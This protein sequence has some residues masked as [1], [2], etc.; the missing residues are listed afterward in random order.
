[1]E[2]ENKNTHWLR[3]DYRV[4]SLFQIITGLDISIKILVKRMKAGGWYDGL[5]LR[6]DCEPIYGLAFLA[7]QN[8]INL[9][10]KDFSGE[11]SNKIKYYKIEPNLKNFEKSSIE[12]IIGLANYLKHRDEKELHKGTREILESFSLHFGNENNIDNSPIFDGLAILSEDWDLFEVLE[13]VKKW[14]EKLWTL[15]N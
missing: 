4:E 14:R 9:S 15:E 8:Y 13:I 5:W 3:C 1:M 12:L 10:I 11:T 6:E 2:I 7:F